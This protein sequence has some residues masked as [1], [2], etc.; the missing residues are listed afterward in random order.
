MLTIVG[1]SN[2]GYRSVYRDVEAQIVIF[3]KNSTLKNE[4]HKVSFC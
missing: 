4:F 1:S 2:F 3:T